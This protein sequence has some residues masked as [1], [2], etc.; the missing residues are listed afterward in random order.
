[1]P[2]REQFEKGLKTL[3][4]GVVDHIRRLTAEVG[5]KEMNYREVLFHEALVDAELARRVL[6]NR[7]ATK[8]R[9]RNSMESHVFEFHKKGFDLERGEATRRGERG[10]E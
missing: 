3:V 7:H 2:V 10:H 1:L 8:C 9:I 4:L 5:L 6:A